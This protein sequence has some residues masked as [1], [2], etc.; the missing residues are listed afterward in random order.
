MANTYSKI[1]YHI[2]FAVKYR[3]ALITEKVKEPLYKYITGVVTNQGQK[4]LIINGHYDHVHLL[5]CCQ[6]TMRVDE[7]VREV[8][9]HSTK[10]L[11]ANNLTPHKFLWQVGYSVFSLSERNIDSVFSYIRHQEQHHSKKK[12]REEHIEMLKAAAIEYDEKY[13]FEELTD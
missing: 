12:F 7:L 11:N 4:L 2:V 3:R 5:V 13:I 8:K 9:E 10:Y 6:P 1:Y